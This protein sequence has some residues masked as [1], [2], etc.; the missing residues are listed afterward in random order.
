MKVLNVCFFLLFFFF[1]FQAEDGIRDIGV[2][3][4]QTCAL[5]ISGNS[6]ECSSSNLMVNYLEEH[7]AEF[8]GVSTGRA[9]L[10]HYPYQDLA[11]QVLG[12]V[13]SITQT[14]LKHLGKGYDPNGDIGQTGAES[15][16]DKYLRG[17]SGAQKL[18]VD[19]LSRPLAAMQ[20]HLVSPYAYLPCTGTYQSPNDKSHQV[21]HNWDPNVNQQMDMPTALAYSCDTYFYQL[22]DRFFSLPKDRGQPLQHW[23]TMF[24]F[25]KLTGSDVGPEVPGLVPTIGWK[26]GHFTTEIDKL[27]KPGD[28]I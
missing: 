23:A 17:V 6:A 1:F 3:G 22:G 8:P 20:Q 25:G 13:G 11:A 10:R 12:Y 9:Y 5:P 7:S 26:I 2:T 21:F 18:H 16:F 14:Q 15:A 4:V 28:S 19:N 27:W 24:G